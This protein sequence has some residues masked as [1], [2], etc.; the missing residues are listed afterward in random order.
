MRCRRAA[1][2]AAV[3]V[4]IG[5][6][7]GAVAPEP[8]D[9]ATSHRSFDDVEHWVSV[10]DDPTRDAWQKPEEV[11]RAL[12][13]EPGMTVADLGAGTGYF[14]PYLA[15][16]V[17]QTGTVLAIET[18]PNLLIHIGE[19]AERARWTNVMPVLASADDPRLPHGGVDRLLIV[20]T[21]HHLDDR[22]AYF[23]R[24]AR[25]LAPGGR[26]V[27]VDWQKRPLPVGPKLDHKL[28][29][30]QVEHEMRRAGYDLLAAPDLLPHQYLLIFRR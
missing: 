4:A 16:A 11:V 25:A 21:Y 10:F 24:A 12:A 3:A 27:I 13:I 30:T 14:L 28:A 7:A 15:A 29:R 9:K 18:E 1:W 6:G 19:R 5:L 8:S 22:V 17:G 26:I 2:L 23:R 20:D